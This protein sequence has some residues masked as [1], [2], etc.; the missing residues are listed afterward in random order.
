[1]EKYEVQISERVDKITSYCPTVSFVGSLLNT[2]PGIQQKYIDIG[3]PEAIGIGFHMP[4][5]LLNSELPVY[6][7]Q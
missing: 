6:Y 5:E 4:A 1:M 3:S 7:K 2:I